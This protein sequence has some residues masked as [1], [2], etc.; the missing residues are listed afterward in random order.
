MLLQ[1]DGEI[2]VDQFLGESLDLV[3]QTLECMPSGH[4]KFSGTM[5]WLSG[6]YGKYSQNEKIET[7]N[8]GKGWNYQP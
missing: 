5:G 1:V 2:P 6:R 8:H 7:C 3:D 4:H